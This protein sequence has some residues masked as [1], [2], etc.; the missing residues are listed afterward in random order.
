MQISC[1]EVL[2][3]LSRYI[4]RDVDPALR[5]DIEEHLS[6][7]SRCTAVFDGTRNVVRLVGDER[8]FELPAGFSQRLKEKIERHLPSH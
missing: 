5:Q 2:R 3:E 1:L 4:D 8:A 7:C 6:H